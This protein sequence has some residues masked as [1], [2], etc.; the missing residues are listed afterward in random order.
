[1][2]NTVIIHTALLC[3]A[4][5]LIDYYRLKKD[6]DYKKFDVF[7][8]NDLIL[9]VSGIGR[10]KATVAVTHILTRMP[11]HSNVIILNIGIAGTTNLEHGI[12]HSFLINKI[13]DF[14]TRRAYYPDILFQHDMPEIS[15]ATFDQIVTDNATTGNYSGLV[16]MESAGVAAAVTTFTGPHQ[17]V[18]YKII[19]DYLEVEHLSADSVSQMVAGQLAEICNLVDQLRA[20]PMATPAQ[21]HYPEQ[22]IVDALTA[23]LRLT[24]AQQ[25]ILTNDLFDAHLKFGEIPAGWQEFIVKVVITKA[26][27]KKQFAALRK[28]LL[29]E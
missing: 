3:E 23:S 20:L 16:D 5:P 2:S 29:G 14:N 4:R 9:I 7:R 19:S 15:V 17:M 1:M 22:T 26:E 25:K 18:F 10:L 13:I 11:E 27:G 12:G 24:T 8:N 28:V 6:F 21:E